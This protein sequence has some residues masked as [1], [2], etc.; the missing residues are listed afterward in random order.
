MMHTHSPNDARL[1]WLRVDQIQPDP[2]QPRKALGDIQALADSIRENGILQP[3]VVSPMGA[4]GADALQKYRIV[5]GERR[6]SAAKLIGLETVPAIVR[7]FEEQQ[8]LEVQLVENLQREDLSP[9]EEATG[10]QRLM[11]EFGLKQRELAERIGKS[12]SAISQILRVLSLPNEILEKVK[13]SQLFDAISRSTLLEIARLP[14]EEEQLALWRKVAEE[15]LT[16]REAR[17][18]KASG[19]TAIHKPGVKSPPIAPPWHPL[20]RPTAEESSPA[21]VRLDVTR[22]VVNVV[23]DRPRVADEDVRQA[24][25]QALGQLAPVR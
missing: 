20:A 10:Y 11:A 21:T 5:S 7:S 16:V 3:I 22:A 8:R 23:F 18:A 6:Y 15:G 25:E 24:L 13:T 2:N 19:P 4:D 1:E 14:T 9:I 17:R 12:P